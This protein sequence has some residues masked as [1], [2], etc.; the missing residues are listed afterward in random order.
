[1]IAVCLYACNLPL[2]LV[3]HEDF[4]RMVFKLAPWMEG[5]LISRKTLATS[6]LDEVYGEVEEQV[7]QWLQEQVLCFTSYQAHADAS[8][9]YRNDNSCVDMTTGAQS[10][11]H[12]C[13]L[14][15]M[16]PSHPI[17]Q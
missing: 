2:S 17:A 1:M 15:F 11:S 6:M 13:S 9:F 4:R 12:T 8:K 3:E 10:C 14:C 7:L 5:K 16:A